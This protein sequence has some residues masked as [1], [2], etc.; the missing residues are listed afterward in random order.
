MPSVEVLLHGESITTNY[1]S[2]GYCSTLLVK[3]DRNIIVDT[4]HVGRRRALL[5]ALDE[6]GMQPSDIDVA[7]MTHAHW[8]HAQNYDVFPDAEVLIHEW[9]RRYARNPHRN[10]WATPRWTSA[11]LDSLANVR[12]VEDG[13]EVEPG[14]RVL[15]TPGHSAGTMAL[16]VE[17]AEGPVAITGDGI[18]NARAAVTKINSNVF[19]N[20]E[21]SRRSIERVLA[22]AEI[23]YPGH[24]RPFRML[25]DGGVERL[26]VRQLA[27][28]GLDLEDPSISAN[29]EPHTPYVMPGVEGQTLEPPA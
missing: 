6:R 17:T 5:A 9:E 26:A 18:A 28:F 11:M 25:E 16:L 29:A 19:W 8:D 3:G 24:D 22:A 1:G 14:V 7:V 13:Y 15:H 10:D 2:L 12:E 27:F 21:D 20:E 4:G 23:V